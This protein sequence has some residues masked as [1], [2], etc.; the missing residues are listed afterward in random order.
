MEKKRVL[1]FS[2][3]NLLSESLE[4]ILSKL[5]DIQITGSWPLDNLVLA[6]C[7]EQP[8]DLVLIA[9]NESNHQQVSTITFHLLDAYPNLPIIRVKLDPNVLLV[10]SSQALPARVADLIEAIRQV[11]ITG[12]YL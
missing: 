2:Q 9:D 10:Y 12:S 11:P 1:L 3:P 5:D 8:C 4:H 6:H 7:S